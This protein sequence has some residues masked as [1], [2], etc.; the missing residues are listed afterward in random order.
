MTSSGRWSTLAL[1]SRESRKGEEAKNPMPAQMTAGAYSQGVRNAL[2]CGLGL[3][4]VTALV[5]AAVA[6]T[7]GLSFR[8]AFWTVW[9]VL[10]VGVMAV[11]FG[12]WLRDRGSGGKVLMDCG[13][14]PT[15]ALFLFNAILFGSLGVGAL[16]L[17]SPPNLVSILGGAFFIVFGIYWGVLSRGRLQLREE[18]IWCYTGLVPWGRIEAS[19]WD[20]NSTLRFR[21]KGVLSKIVSS[22][23]PVPPEQQQEF[24]KI[25]QSHCPE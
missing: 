24:E 25:L 14:H 20:A 17:F 12:L 6:Q 15:R 2:V 9:A 8:S 5:G 21:T 19:S 3:V 23:I 16:L 1:K 22:A 7:A 13:P 10:A 4:G 18:G 11:F